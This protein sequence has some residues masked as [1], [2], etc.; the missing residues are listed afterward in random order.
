MR[1]RQRKWI[2][3]KCISGTL[4]KVRRHSDGKCGKRGLANS[5]ECTSNLVFDYI[6]LF[7]CFLLLWAQHYKQACDIQCIIVFQSLKFI[8]NIKKYNEK[9]QKKDSLH[10]H[11]MVCIWWVNCTCWCLMRRPQWFIKSTN[12]ISVCHN[13]GN[14]V[15]I[16]LSEWWHAP[17][18]T[19]PDLF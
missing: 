15:I 12:Q 13:L 4:E 11:H 17:K 16:L 9:W 8:L 14:D 7:V 10:T 3:D 19:L 1:K 18:K 2:I 5:I 6:Y